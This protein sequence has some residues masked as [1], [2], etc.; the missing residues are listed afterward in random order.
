MLAALAPAVEVAGLQQQHLLEQLQRTNAAVPFQGRL[1]GPHNAFLK[2]D[3][4]GAEHRSYAHIVN[5]C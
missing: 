5:I 4:G 2:V 1:G 3:L